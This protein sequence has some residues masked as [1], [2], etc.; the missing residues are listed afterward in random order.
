MPGGLADAFEVVVA[1]PVQRLIDQLAGKRA[2]FARARGLLASDPC[3]AELGAYRLSGPLA[4]VVCGVRLDNDYRLAFTTQPPLVPADDD[5]ARVV[6]LYVGKRE[7]L[8]GAADI[9]EVL[10]ELFDVDKE[11]ATTSSCSC[12]G[13]RDYAARRPARVSMSAARS[14]AGMGRASR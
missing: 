14:S 12:T 5:R 2:G 8:H 1:P 3:S 9:W 13:A 6:I 11:R 4:P 7:P 10:H